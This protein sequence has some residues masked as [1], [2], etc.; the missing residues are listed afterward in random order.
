MAVGGLDLAR[1]IVKDDVDM[2]MHE[3]NSH[4]DYLTV[5]DEVPVREG[6]TT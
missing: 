2:N 6:K 4:E 1:R 5:K 3:F